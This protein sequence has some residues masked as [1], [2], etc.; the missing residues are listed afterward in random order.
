MNIYNIYTIYSY[1]EFISFIIN[2]IV[3]SIV[4]ENTIDFSLFRII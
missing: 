2:T 4:N 3:G 1:I